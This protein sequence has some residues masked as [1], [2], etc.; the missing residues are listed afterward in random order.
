MNSVRLA[1]A[2][3]FVISLSAHAAP[4]GA[5]TSRTCNGCHGSAN[6]QSWGGQLSGLNSGNFVSRLQNGVVAMEALADDDVAADATDRAA[7]LP[8]LL[9][10]RD[11]KADVIQ[12]LAFG[13]VAVGD[14]RNTG[15]VRI[16]NERSRSITYA[17][18]SFTGEAGFSVDSESC[19][20]RTVAAGGTCDIRIRFE[21]T[22]L[23]GGVNSDARS[24]NL[25]LSFSGSGGDND[26]LPRSFALSG[27]AIAPIVQSATTLSPSALVG[28]SDTRSVVFTNQS[29]SGITI[30]SISFSG[31]YAAE[32]TRDASS[33]CTVGAAISAS[34][35]CTLVVRFTPTDGVP[36]SRPASVAVAYGAFGSPRTVAL[37]GTSAPQGRIATS[38][39]AL[40]FADTQL[41]ASSAQSITV[42]NDGNATLQITALSITG[43]HAG[44]YT[45]SGTCST[46]SPLAVGANCT[47]TITFSPAALGSRTATLTMTHDG[48]NPSEGVIGLS[49]T[50]VPIPAPAVSLA[51]SGGLDFGA[52]SLGG[53]YPPRALTLTNSGTA[54]LNVASIGV[55]GATF[56]DVSASPC[57][58]TLSPSQSC[59]IQVAFAPAA[60]G[61]SYTGVV[62]II[63]NAAGSPHTASLAGSGTAAA[64]PVL[65]WT[66]AISQLDFGNV[67]V[68]TVSAAQSATLRNDGPGGV[69]IS[70]VN[71]VGADAAMFPVGSDPSDTTACHAGRTL[72]EGQTCRVDVRFAPG[73]NGSR[74]ATVQ[75]ASS[76]S[77][78]PVLTAIGTGLG[79]TTGTMSLSQS[80]IDLGQTRVGST[81]QPADL[82]VRSS[83]GTLRVLSIAVTGPFSATS[84][85][86]PA[87]PFTLT[88][89]MECSIGVSF[90]PR[91]EGAASGSLEVTSESSVLSVALS[92][93][94]ESKADL[95]SGGCSIAG[96]TTL[97]DPTLWVLALLALAALLYR[98]RAHRRDGRAR[99]RGR[100]QHER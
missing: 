24:G 25:N 82:I 66:P 67:S 31:T 3:W 59:Q 50:G 23:P 42:S 28:S 91:S 14:S 75:V 90:A 86:C 62:S 60:A 87:A 22:S 2:A 5:W 81:S 99:R 8:Y 68:G 43:S 21:P 94:G 97:V 16:T 47:V 44:D 72:F 71:S 45:R 85:T 30:S 73:A 26:P 4:P 89:G 78:P 88:A 80:V 51:P 52:Q 58:A 11:G 13:S 70:V 33:T 93:T 6:L 92:G 48:S 69:T 38:T 95:S 34:G 20:S 19:G 7:I 74:S 9:D 17:A 100:A 12:S 53:L 1:I 61:A 46:A 96:G 98:H 83:G 29:G 41:G 36:S 84:R 40:S 56:S 35:N 39:S 65:S 54:A 10:V 32:Y 63:S 49:G 37:N 77:A 76:G 57:P 27:T 55:E 64:V 15:L 79:G 18:P